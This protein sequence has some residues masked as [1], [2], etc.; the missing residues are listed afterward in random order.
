M[1]RYIAL[2]AEQHQQLG[3]HGIDSLKFAAKTDT[4]PVLLEELPHLIPTMPV[5]FLELPAT[6][7][8]PAR[9]EAV[10]L[11]SLI[12][13]HNLFVAPNGRWMGGYL[14]AALRAYPF[15]LLP[16]KDKEGL[17]LC[18]DQTSGLLTDQPTEEQRFFKPDGKPSDK[19][20]ALLG[21]M[22]QCEAGRA[23]TRQAVSLLAKHNL[24]K[25]WSLKLA[26]EKGQNAQIKGI[27]RVDEAALNSLSAE[28]LK[29]LQEGQ[30]LAL[31]YGQM[32]SQQRIKGFQKLYQLHTKLE[33]HA[34]SVSEEDV[35]EYFEG[36]DDTLSFNF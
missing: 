26:T 15:R 16:R 27:Y 28:A 6:D 19:L 24:I 7:T 36:K 14:P 35:A 10:A 11:L 9:F 12:P 32:L 22:Q 8:T 18:F 33:E 23:R 4:A 13:D 30:A 5:A 3:W 21:F 20:N 34:Q 1:D 17:A 29:E 2:N 31:A 25:P